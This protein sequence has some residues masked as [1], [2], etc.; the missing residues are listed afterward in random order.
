MCSNES[1]TGILGG[2]A[3]AGRAVGVKL[4]EK[5]GHAAAQAPAGPPAVSAPSVPGAPNENATANLGRAMTQSAAH[6]ALRPAARSSAPAFTSRWCSAR[7]LLIRQ[8]AVHGIVLD[9]VAVA[10]ALPIVAFFTVFA[11]YLAR[12]DEYKRHRMI[13]A[14]LISLAIGLSITSGWDF[15]QAYGSAPG[16]EPFIITSGFML[17]FGVIHAAMQIIDKFGSKGP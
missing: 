8:H 5:H 12:I 15:L 10:P 17:L 11:R 16:P 1:W 3:A 6:R 2:V 4:C 13:Q 7:S 9:L 14:L